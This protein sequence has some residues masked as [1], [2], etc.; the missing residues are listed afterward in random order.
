MKESMAKIHYDFTQTTTYTTP[1]SGRNAKF[2]DYMEQYVSNAKDSGKEMDDL[3][4]NESDPL[5]LQNLSELRSGIVSFYDFKK[6]ASVLEIGASFGT[7]TETLLRKCAH[8]TVTEK[9]VFRAE[10]L[11]KRFHCEE[12]KDSKRVDGIARTNADHLDIYVGDVQDMIFP[13]K[14]DYVILV[15]LL[16]KLF[17]GPFQVQEYASYLSYLKSLLTESG[18]LLIAVDNRLGLKYLAGGVDVNTNQAFSGLNNYPDGTK[19]RSF[20]KAE[21]DQMISLAGFR[22]RKYYYPLP[23]Y[24]F[25][26]LIYTD[27]HLPELN[28]RERLIPYYFRKDTLVF[29]ELSLYTDVIANGGFPFVAN[30]FL[31]ECTDK[32]ESICDISYAAIS[33]DRGSDFSFVTAIH[34]DESVTKTP[35][36]YSKNHS[37]KTLIENTEDLAAHGIPVLK[38]EV[39]GK[40]QEIETEADVD[41]ISQSSIISLKMPYVKYDTLS[42]YIKQIISTDTDQV[43]TIIDKIYEF[44]LQSSET[45]GLGEDGPIL[46]KA[47][48]ELIPL[49][50]FYNPEKREYIFF[51]QEFAV[52][53][54]P[55]KYVLFRAIHYIF[56]FTPGVNQY[57]SLQK[58]KQKY[59]M[60]STWDGYLEMEKEFL[61]RV[62]NHEKY[63]WFYKYAYADRNR[64]KENADR[65][66]SE[67][68]KKHDYH[69]SDKMKKTWSV[70]LQMLDEIDR[71]CKKHNITYYMVHGTLLG[72]VRHKG[73][74]PWDDD[75]DIAMKRADYD[76]F[77]SIARGELAAPLCLMLPTDDT[78]IWW[79]AFAR[80]M[81]EN[82]TAIL[83]HNMNRKGKQGIWIDILPLDIATDNETL[84]HR[85]QKKL[86]AIHR[87]MNAKVAEK[88]NHHV[89]GM[90]VLQTLYYRV[91]ASFLSK[92]Q[93]ANRLDQAMR[94]YTDKETNDVAIFTGFEKIKIF[95]ASDF[96]ETVDLE[97][98]GRKL[99]AP[100]GYEDYLFRALGGDYMKFPPEEERKPK[101]RGIFDPFRPYTDYLQLLSNTFE[102]AKGKEI[103]LFGSGLM[104]EDYMKKYGDKFKPSF[105]VDNDENKWGRK[106]MGIDI[107]S[108][109][110]ILDVP[111]DKRFVII[112]SYYYKEIAPQLEKMGINK[113]KVYVQELEWIMKAEEK[114]QV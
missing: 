20:T 18:V 51:D 22:N 6:D 61:N 85:K 78:D 50:C 69:I 97:F 13:K 21:L 7:I 104:F 32:L 16:E 28:L 4:S 87:L 57:L 113:Y 71:I 114:D 8:V 41:A 96:A 101:H 33:T 49:N 91:R 25:P 1:L 64:I 2:A 48:M 105:I 34:E 24:R 79:G 59:G 74:I 30:S 17:Q 58:L 75:L 66:A 63:A 89:M 68:E 5:I 90:G 3:L 83:P 100:V 38:H 109:K 98:E 106:R 23:D 42:N 36:T 55:A 88:D 107:K 92:K 14:F 27:K 47:Y 80:V 81:N 45:V 76:R 37:V 40:S 56:C 43:L 54:C 10:M 86:E 26:Q 12:N 15:G 73:F 62:R 19:G 11:Y 110:E 44:I 9:S 108:P 52:D 31:V 93:L 77:I 112:C 70:E 35:I 60:E 39:I 67:A 72:A 29:D 46:R 111:V 82:T 103:I 65:L 102:G 99:P 84:F 53:N 95:N 94:L